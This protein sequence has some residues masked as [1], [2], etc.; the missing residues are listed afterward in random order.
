MTTRVMTALRNLRRRGAVESQLD[1]EMR[2]HLDM[3]T[4]SYTKIGGRSCHFF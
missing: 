1:E 2:F 4:V 3:E